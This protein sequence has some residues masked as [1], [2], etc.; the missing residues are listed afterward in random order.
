VPA[1][2][3]WIDGQVRFASP[4]L[5]RPA[6]EFGRWIQAVHIVVGEQR[7]AGVVVKPVSTELSLNR[8]S[9]RNTSAIVFAEASSTLTVATSEGFDDAVGVPDDC[10]RR[11]RYT[12]PVTKVPRALMSAPPHV[13]ARVKDRSSD[14]S[15]TSAVTHSVAR[16]ELPGCGR[17]TTPSPTPAP[18]SWRAGSQPMA[19]SRGS[20][21]HWRPTAW[22]RRGH[23][24]IGVSRFPMLASQ[25]KTVSSVPRPDS[26][27]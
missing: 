9:E 8:S 11:H 23:T 24:G 13:G 6:P 22:R 16:V 20:P 19:P 10:S 3:Q 7:I 14:R 2:R 26:L 18:G 25:R 21:V 17:S 4:H 15:M 1:E 27:M 12:Q 5:D